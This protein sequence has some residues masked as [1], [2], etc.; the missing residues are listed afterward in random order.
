MPSLFRLFRTFPTKILALMLCVFVVGGLIGTGEVNAHPMAPT[1]LQIDMVNAHEVVVRWKET[2]Q[3]AMAKSNSSK[4]VLP[5]FPDD[6]MSL[7]DPA[8]TAEAMAIAYEWRLKCDQPL[9][10]REI[11]IA[12]MDSLQNQVFVAQRDLSGRTEVM[13]LGN[14][15]NTLRMSEGETPSGVAVRYL[16]TGIEHLLSG[17][18][19]LLFVFGLFVLLR[20]Q[21]SLLLMAVT[22]FTLGHSLT[23]ALASLGLIPAGTRW[24]EI[25]IALSIT[26]IGLEI[27]SSQKQLHWYSVKRSPFMLTFAFGLI[28]GCGFAAI[29]SEVLDKEAS[30]VLPLFA[31]NMG[32]EIAQ[33]S[34]LLLL[35]YAERFGHAISHRV[36]GER[37]Q[38]VWLRK[39]LGYSMGGISVYWLLVRTLG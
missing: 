25:G 18:D 27:L 28:H 15:N 11:F 14:G 8:V 9:Q 37:L 12:N 23:L 26:L 39:G 32:I 3:K 34:V 6:C 33:C 29:L 4:N 24:V 2:T 16:G 30:P 20:K 1:L 19:H 17:W 5:V 35:V 21:M 13:L 7:G 38:T 36:A 22:A 31:F 10:G